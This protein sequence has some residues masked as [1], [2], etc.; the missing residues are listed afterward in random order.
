[1]SRGLAAIL[2]EAHP[3]GTA[4]AQGRDHVHDR[5]RRRCDRLRAGSGRV[6][7]ARAVAATVV[8]SA[9]LNLGYYTWPQTDLPT[10]RTKLTYTN[11]GRHGGHARSLARLAGRHRCP[12][13]RLALGLTVTIPAGAEASIDVLLDPSLPGTG[14]F[15]G[16]VIA[17]GP[18]GRWPVPPSASASRASITT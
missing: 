12:D 13:G 16:V 18:T 10:T 14:S 5:S 7:A 2:K 1:M 17:S 11:I 15:S 8:A 4:T 9:S 3:D 6:D